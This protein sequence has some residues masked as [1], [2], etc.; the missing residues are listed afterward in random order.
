MLARL[1][2]VVGSLVAAALFSALIAPYFVDWTNFRQDFENQA[3]RIIGKKVVV[4]GSVD[5][6]LLPFPSVTLTDVRV[7][8]DGQGGA[9]VSARS[10]SMETELAPFLSGEALIYNMRIDQPKVTLKLGADGALD[11][12]KTGEPRIPAA[13]VVLEKVQVADGE[14]VFIDEQTGRTRKLTGLDLD[15]SAKTLAG[16]WKMAGTGALD[17]QRG[18]FTLA[19]N[20]PEND[21]VFLKLRLM[22]QSPA[23]AA[24][25]EGLIGLKDLRPEYAG[26][27]RLRRQLAS[28]REGGETA[29]AL[30]ASAPRIQGD[31][32]LNN[33]RIRID[34][35]QFSMGPV[36]DPYTVTGEATIDAGRNPEFLLTAAG[37]Q[38]DMTRIG[39]GEGESAALPLKDRLRAFLALAGDIPVPPMPG[40]AEITLPALIADDTVIRNIT[41]KTRPTGDGWII[42]QA[43]AELP[44]RTRLSAKGKLTLAAAQGFQG[45]LL[46]AS[47][48][49]SGFAEWVTGETPDA[50]R[51][52]KTAGFSANVSLTPDLQRFENL[53]IVFG[54]ARLTGRLEH[55]MND[56]EQPALSTELSG[57]DFDLDT[58]TALA[59]LL[60]GE[61]QTAD[62]LD[63]RIG[64]RLKFDH[65]SG[66]GLE[67]RDLDAAISLSQG[68]L[69]DARVTLGDFYG[70]QI[71]VQG[72]FDRL[73]ERPSGTARVSMKSEDP[74]RLFALMAERL[75]G[76]P[77]LARLAGNA[78]YYAGSDFRIDL[79]VGKGDWPIEA[80]LSGIAHGSRMSARLAAQSL[81]L[82]NSGGLTLDATIENPDAWVLLG[83]AGLK[84][85]PIDA[86]QDGL[87]TLK[88]NQPAE[89]DPQINLAFSSGTTDLSITGQTALEAGRFLSGSYAL[90][91][92]SG[93]IAPYLAM[94]GLALPR[95]IEGL[96]FSLTANIYSEKDAVAFESVAGKADGNVFSGAAS[97][98][99]TQSAPRLGGE[100]SV[101]AVDFGWLAETVYGPL[102][103]L[104]GDLSAAP[105][106]KRPVTPFNVSLGLT[107]KTMRIGSLASIGD[108]SSRLTMEPGRLA[109][110]G[111]RGTLLGGK[112]SGQAELGDTEGSGYLR[113]RLSVDDADLKTGFW[114]FAGQPVATARADLAMTLDAAGDDP[115]A[116]LDGATG[117]GALTLNGVTLNGLNAAALPSLLSGADRID[118]E[119]TETALRPLI[120]TA[121]FSGA[122]KA[123]TLEIPF[124]IAGSR[125]RADK[126]T[127]VMANGARLDAQGAIGLADGALDGQLTLAYDPGD[128]R[129]SGADPSVTLTFQGP[130]AAPERKADITAMSNFLSLRKFEQERRRVEILQATMQEKQRL[131]RETML[132][133][134]RDA[135]RERLRLKA[136][137][138][139]RLL[140]EQQEALARLAREEEERRQAE[141]AL[142]NSLNSG[143]PAAQ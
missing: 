101:D 115:R 138:E 34:K 136:L 11:W 41:L 29:D 49:P 39:G 52:L 89:A 46:L 127:G 99:R 22:P 128:E 108:F 35:Y 90:S 109:L 5:A 95:L 51:R 142:G 113:A 75:P 59:G 73:A 140:R 105:L 131:R 40:R 60:T 94:N 53:E 24:E 143:Q 31:F 58:M 141:K 8:E 86:D 50:I 57:N 18:S 54:D 25:M 4:H 67:A 36:D 139:A 134:A 42:D 96:P 110:S 17:G 112:F 80:T 117:S 103:D 126:V 6:R 2:I 28:E 62:L 27:F 92:D 114:R 38:V 78:G 44:G 87:L 20:V 137:D 130:F 93:D 116:L 14:V 83:Q 74:S 13:S 32:R 106:P 81:D 76:H 43:E 68:A 47:N 9:L 119:F 107:A 132:W 124:A 122:I 84:T 69:T 97:L 98:D 135:E 7:G 120:E 61:T 125:L 121:L 1:F 45:Q 37:Q 10:F 85:L 129:M 30:S 48:Q 66:L 91:L 100:F 123:N 56:G 55:E 118:G 104:S 19:T 102:F 82:A 77:A 133:K 111:A 65:F 21:K 26:S 23:I 12:V 16:P 88:I 15:L 79:S 3:S 63:H 70:A 64:A 72:G 71:G 33:D